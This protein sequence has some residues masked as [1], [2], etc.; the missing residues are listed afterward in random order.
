ME[1]AEKYKVKEF[2]KTVERE[3]VYLDDGQIQEITDLFVDAVSECLLL[4]M[5]ISHDLLAKIISVT[6]KRMNKRYKR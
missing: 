5:A 3:R 4:G 2:L 6:T 1:D